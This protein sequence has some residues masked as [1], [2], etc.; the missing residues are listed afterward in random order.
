MVLTGVLAG[1]PGHRDSKTRSLRIG[2]SLELNKTAFIIG[3]ARSGTKLLRDLMATH[4]EVSR[5]PYDINFIWKWGNEDLSH[6]QLTAEHL[7]EDIREK[8]QFEIERFRRD[9]PV[10]VEKTV[11]NTLRVDFVSDCFP[12][13]VFVHLKRCGIDTIESA[14]RQWQARPDALYVLRKAL[15]FPRLFVQRYG[16]KYLQSLISRP[17]GA[18]I[19]GPCYPGMLEDLATRSLLEVC[20][21]QWSQ[22][23][24]N[25]RKQLER[26]SPSRVFE[27]AYEDVV[28]E[29]E[30]VLSEL[31]DF[32]GL[33]VHPVI[34][35]M[36]KRV[37]TSNVGKGRRALSEEQLRSVAPYV[38][39]VQGGV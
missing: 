25:A 26:V 16:W 5:V 31:Y 20:A 28:M 29:P 12:Q 38:D 39:S 36:E 9:R 15:T 8:I 30:K 14:Y 17:S 3:P 7:T 23:A 37:V 19:W 6:D 24:G 35:E 10:L 33:S 18:R 21:I 13:A 34:D 32:V 22:C 11:S 4:P 1:K 27:V 2:S